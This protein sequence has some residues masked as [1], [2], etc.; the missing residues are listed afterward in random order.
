MPPVTIDQFEVVDSP[1]PSPA[2]TERSDAPATR[3][4]ADAEDLRR[5]LAEQAERS[6]RRWSH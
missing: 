1:Q 5:A 2:R 4:R 3:P 6:L